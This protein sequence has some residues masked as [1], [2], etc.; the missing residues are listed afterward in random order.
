MATRHGHSEV[1][2][3]YDHKMLCCNLDERWR[4]TGSWHG[5]VSL[6]SSMTSL[7]AKNR[8]CTWS[9]GSARELRLPEG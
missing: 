8:Q 6:A 4:C 3:Y 9:A 1:S 5:V 7:R 2:V